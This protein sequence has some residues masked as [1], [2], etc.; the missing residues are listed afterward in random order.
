M[1]PKRVKTL[2]F[3]PEGQGLLWA[4][5]E[6]SSRLASTVNKSL[7]FGF[8]QEEQNVGAPLRRPD[9]IVLAVAA[10]F[11]QVAM[12]RSHPNYPQDG[13]RGYLTTP[14]PFCDYL[15]GLDELA[16]KEHRRAVECISP[17]QGYWKTLGKIP[18][19]TLPAGM[20]SR[21]G[22]KK[23][24]L[25]APKKDSKDLDDDDVAFK[26]KLKEQQKALQEAKSKASQKGP[27]AGGGIKKSG[28]K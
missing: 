9:D 20:S 3:L 19:S 5:I 25:K 17:P 15:R 26:Q 14:F 23:K 11:T 27:L 7:H 8:A 2:I 1:I 18:P 13:M 6:R 4:E 21:E 28:K 16:K 24:P 12:I 10:Q 22:G